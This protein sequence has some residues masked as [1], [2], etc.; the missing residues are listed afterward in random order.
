MSTEARDWGAQEV[1]AAD[2]AAKREVIVRG[3]FG[4]QI[5]EVAD[6]RGDLQ[7]VV[8]HEI[9]AVARRPAP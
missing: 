5:V 6:E 1:V 9:E 4:R 7:D 3:D 2:L 8:E